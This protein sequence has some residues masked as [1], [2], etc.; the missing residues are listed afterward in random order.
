MVDEFER[1]A[2]FDGGFNFGNHVVE[3]IN[4]SLGIETEFF[5]HGSSILQGLGLV[6]N[7]LESIGIGEDFEEGS[8]GSVE[9][10]DGGL[11]GLT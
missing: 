4:G 6:Y 11:S 2:I 5:T 3:G 9:S 1:H 10:V 7:S 8:I